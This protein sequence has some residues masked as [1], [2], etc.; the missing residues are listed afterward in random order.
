[1]TR[2]ARPYIYDY[3]VCTVECS[4]YARHDKQTDKLHISVTVLSLR[5][6]GLYSDT[7]PQERTATGGDMATPRR[8]AVL[9]LA[10]SA[11]WMWLFYYI[12]YYT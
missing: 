11:R 12:L 2:I 5:L 4:L 10:V 8:V 7:A 3:T 6:S 1:M 9:L